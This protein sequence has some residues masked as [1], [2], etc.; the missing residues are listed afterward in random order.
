M[1]Y[2]YIVSKNSKKFQ[3]PAVLAGLLGWKT[4]SDRVPFAG[5]EKIAV[6][7]KSIS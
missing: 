7:V 4:Q 6:V 1:Q 2:M 5:R 3:R